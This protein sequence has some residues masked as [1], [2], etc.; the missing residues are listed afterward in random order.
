M[1]LLSLILVIVLVGVLLWAINRFIPMD[2]KISRI[3]NAVVVIG[4]ILWLLQVFGILGT[5]GNIRLSHDDRTHT[6]D[7]RADLTL[8]RTL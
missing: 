1:S 6:T 3:L 4:L 7:H 2:A 5:I 8:G